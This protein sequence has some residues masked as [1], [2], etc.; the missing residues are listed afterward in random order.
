MEQFEYSN[1]E[2]GENSALVN[3]TTEFKNM[4]SEFKDSVLD[5]ISKNAE[6]VKKQDARIESLEKVVDVLKEDNTKIR[7]SSYIDP[8][9]VGFIS[10]RVKDKVQELFDSDRIRNCSNTKTRRLLRNDIYNA[11]KSKCGLRKGTSYK[12]LK[13]KDYN[14]ALEIVEGYILPADLEMRI[15]EER[16]VEVMNVA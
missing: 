6:V 1:A 14:F 13:A 15:I 9:Q 5:I 8:Y 16:T 3:I 2:M 7:E 4:I 12:Y 11:I 10:D